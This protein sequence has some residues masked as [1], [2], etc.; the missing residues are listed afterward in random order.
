MKKTMRVAKSKKK[1]KEK[2][3]LMN[4]SFFLIFASNYGDFRKVSKRGNIN[5]FFP[6]YKSGSTKSNMAHAK[7][8]LKVTTMF[9]FFAPA[10]S[11][12]EYIWLR[13]K[14]YKFFL[15]LISC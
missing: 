1:T 8:Y 4:I 9:I 3:R 14:E 2:N 12:C 6:S 5:T 15:T 7:K 13:G 10:M 11:E